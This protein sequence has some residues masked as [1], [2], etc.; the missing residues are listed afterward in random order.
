MLCPFAYRPR[1]F[2]ILPVFTFLFR[3]RRK[4]DGA[5]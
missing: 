1:R 2:V 5:T 4:D 3:N